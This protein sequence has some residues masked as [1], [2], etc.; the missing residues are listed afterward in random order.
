MWLSKEVHIYFFTRVYSLRFSLSTQD[1]YFVAPLPLSKYCI[2]K[3]ITQ[4]A[5]ALTYILFRWCQLRHHTKIHK[6]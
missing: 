3:I 4:N 1:T 6:L 2:T 5:I